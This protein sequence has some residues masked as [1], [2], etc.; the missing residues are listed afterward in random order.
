MSLRKTDRDAFDTWRQLG[1]EAP[2]EFQRVN[3]NIEGNV[4]KVVTISKIG[5]MIEVDSNHK[6]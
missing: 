6:P 2:K 3:K 4:K 5:N 1:K